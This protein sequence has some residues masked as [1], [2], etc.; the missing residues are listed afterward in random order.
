MRRTITI[1]LAAAALAACERPGGEGGAREP[2]S[3]PGQVDGRAV[4][5]VPDRSSAAVDTTP[6]RPGAPDT[7]RAP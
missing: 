1:V 3:V 4:G 7:A 5:N 6:H 2:A